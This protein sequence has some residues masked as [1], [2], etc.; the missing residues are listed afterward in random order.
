MEKIVAV[1]A[2]EGEVLIEV[3]GLESGSELAVLRAASGRVF[4]MRHRQDCCEHVRLEEIHGDLSDLIGAVVLSA[5]ESTNTDNPP[6]ENPDSWTWTFYRIQTDRGPVVLRWLGE[7]NGY[8]G[9]G[10]DIWE[11]L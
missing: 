11:V 4:E 10:V 8:Y 1:T 7:S 6:P 2:L 9:E 5:E 3:T